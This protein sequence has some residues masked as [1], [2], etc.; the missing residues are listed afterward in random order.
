M[1]SFNFIEI[2]PAFP[3]IFLL[4]SAVLLLLL[5]AWKGNAFFES[6]C[7]LSVGFI[8]VSLMIILK[9]PHTEK[10]AFYG[11]FVSNSFTVYAK[12]LILLGTS[13]SIIMVMGYFRK[14]EFSGKFEIPVLMLLAAVGMMCMVSANNL[15]TLYTGLELQSLC[16]YVLA[17]VKRDSVRSSEAGL[18]YFMLGAL[19]SGLLL[20]GSSLIYG[21]SGTTDFAEIAKLFAADVP[22][23][24]GVLVGLILVIVALCFKVSAVPFHMWTPDVYEGAPAPVTAFFAAAPKVAALVL[25]IRVLMGPFVEAMGEWSQ[26]VIFVSA[27]SM[28]IGALGAIRQTNIKRLMAYS[29]IGHVGYAL[30]GLAVGTPA[31][32][33]A[34]MV[35]LTIYITM[36]LGAFA[37]IMMMQFNDQQLERIDDFSGLARGRPLQAIA[38]AIFMLSLAGIPPLAGFFGKYFIFLAVINAKFYVLA[39][40]GALSS[41]VGAY[42]YLR[43]IKVIYFDEPKE[44]LD[45]DTQLEMQLV[46]LT[47]AAF[48]LLLFI[49]PTPL[50]IVAEMAVRSLFT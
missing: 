15:I 6:L 31:G 36:S 17:A 3:E 7:R 20:Y 12:L 38:V 26:A 18:K 22:L 1:T 10:L 45:K 24:L 32:I 11:M 19:A 39:V 9:L 49:S 14:E 44:S 50:F 8:L 27:A 5:G 21:F 28:V 23:P 48:N 35:Y 41:V 42:Y 34:I 4:L 25:F 29:S 33:T 47:A 13:F 16:L 46:A 2:L 37:C 43:V 30:M 40:I